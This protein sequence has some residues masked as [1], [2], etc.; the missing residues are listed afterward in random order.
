MQA[1]ASQASTAHRT[2]LIADD[3]PSAPAIA[4]ACSTFTMCFC[5]SIGRLQKRG[6]RVA[7]AEKKVA[8]CGFGA[9][10][11]S[12]S[13]RC[14]VAREAASSEAAA[15]T[16]AAISGA[17]PAM[18]VRLAATCGTS[19]S[20]RCR[21]AREA[22][23]SEAAAVT[24]AAIIGA[25]PLMPSRRATASTSSSSRS[26]SSPSSSSFAPS[27]AATSALAPLTPRRRS[28]SR[29]R[30]QRGC[31]AEAIAI[32]STGLERSGAAEGAA[33]SGSGGTIVASSCARASAF[34][35]SGS[36]DSTPSGE[37]MRCASCT[38]TFSSRSARPR[39]TM[40]RSPKVRTSSFREASSAA[41]HA[42]RISG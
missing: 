7:A 29:S 11:T 38:V 36:F 10:G 41:R 27:M 14:R 2:A 13:S 31:S 12:S 25:V 35:A 42:L 39:A 33:A 3:A 23:S 24:S 21:V 5:A 17:T 4:A 37:R 40:R 34:S 6:A 15:A 26:S 18:R 1:A 32:Q 19:A 30:A 22:S 20:S 28:S 16:S 9:R 8:S